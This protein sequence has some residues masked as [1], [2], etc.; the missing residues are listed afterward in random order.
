MKCVQSSL[1][2]TAVRNVVAMMLGGL[3]IKYKYRGVIWGPHDSSRAAWLLVTSCS[4]R[5]GTWKSTG[6]TSET[7]QHP[8]SISI[9]LLKMWAVSKTSHD[10]L[11]KSCFTD[12]Q[13]TRNPSTS[14][15]DCAGRNMPR[16]FQSVQLNVWPPKLIPL[17]ARHFMAW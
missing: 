17:Q 1:N 4:R 5:P 6:N 12:L 9:S 7:Y 3:L 8:T 14:T 13:R 15:P 10:V 2:S 11:R 16:I